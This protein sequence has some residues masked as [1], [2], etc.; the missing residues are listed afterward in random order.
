MKMTARHFTILSE[1]LFGWILVC[2]SLFIA[3]AVVGGEGSWIVLDGF[4]A[5]RSDC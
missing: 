5:A 4:S 2:S 1:S 3:V